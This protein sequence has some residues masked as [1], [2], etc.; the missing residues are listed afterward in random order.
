MLGRLQ[1]QQ[2]QRRP[3]LLVAQK[4]QNCCF[5]G[6]ETS[7]WWIMFVAVCLL[8]SLFLW[9]LNTLESRR[10]KVR[11]DQVSKRHSPTF[12]D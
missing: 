8:S 9:S 12:T 1:Q 7:T 4:C 5:C 2:Q 3:F 11:E 10:K 6:L